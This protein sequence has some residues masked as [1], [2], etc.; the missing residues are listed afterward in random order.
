MI[1]YEQLYYDSLYRNRELT[2]KNNEL[3]ELLEIYKD[4]LKNKGI[5]EI[6]VKDFIKYLKNRKDDKNDGI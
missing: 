5:K 6:I 3:E 2:K 1:D 4:I